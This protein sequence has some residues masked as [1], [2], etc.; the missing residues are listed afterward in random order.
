MNINSSSVRRD[1]IEVNALVIAYRALRD[2]QCA[3]FKI[4]AS[5]LIVVSLVVAESAPSHGDCSFNTAKAERG[6]TT[7]SLRT[8][9][10]ELTIADVELSGR[11]VEVWLQSKTAADR[12][13][14]RCVCDVPNKTAA[15]DVHAHTAR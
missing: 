15:G 5:S 6:A 10:N 11:A 4:N 3:A 2:E 12:H 8:I 13:I 14:R 9:A 7:A 1:S